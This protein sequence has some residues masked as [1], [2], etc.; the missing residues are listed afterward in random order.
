M[1]YINLRFT[2]LYFTLLSPKRCQD[3]TMPSATERLD[4]GDPVVNELDLQ[5]WPAHSCVISRRRRKR[6][7]RWS[8]ESRQTARHFNVVLQGE[9]KDLVK[10]EIYIVE[11]CF[12][13]LIISHTL[14]FVIAS[15][16][17][18]E[19]AGFFSTR[20][21]YYRIVYPFSWVCPGYFKDW[22]ANIANIANSLD[23]EQYV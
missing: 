11:R 14:R 1:R 15:I 6:R 10:S 16:T 12:M 7:L 23:S 4:S 17:F 18:H 9:D 19:N 13:S 2:L 22:R 3:K 8:R 20:H 5:Q 21:I